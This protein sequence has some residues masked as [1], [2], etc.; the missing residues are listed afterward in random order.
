MK[1]ILIIVIIALVVGIVCMLLFSE[2]ERVRYHEATGSAAPLHTVI[3][4]SE[5][6]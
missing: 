3:I 4:S 5:R 1:K 2:P 6:G